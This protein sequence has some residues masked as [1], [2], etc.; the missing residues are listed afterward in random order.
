[1]CCAVLSGKFRVSAVVPCFWDS[2]PGRRA[3]AALPRV[4]RLKKLDV[5]TKTRTVEDRLVKS[6]EVE[7]REV[8][9]RVVEGREEGQ[10][11]KEKEKRQRKEEE[12]EN[13]PIV[14]KKREEEQMQEKMRAELEAGN[15]RRSVNVG[16]RR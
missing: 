14:P 4:V 7:D 9:G 5:V 3:R 10:A 2:T 11:N 13:L 15:W 1:M 12:K 8:G 6:R 16:S